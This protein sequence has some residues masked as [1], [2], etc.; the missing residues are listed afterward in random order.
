MF[1]KFI[2]K[3]VIKLLTT[4]NSVKESLKKELQ[5]VL[6]D[7]A[8]IKKFSEIARQESVE[9]VNSS[10]VQFEEKIE[11]NCKSKIDEAIE[12]NSPG[13]T[14]DDFDTL[15]E[16]I[17]SQVDILENTIANNVTQTKKLLDLI[18][19]L[20][21]TEKQ[22]KSLSDS[23]NIVSQIKSEYIET[24]KKTRADVAAIITKVKQDISDLEIRLD[25]FIDTISERIAEFK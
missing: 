4:D 21:N 6:I 16:Q 20:E 7:E 15:Q 13:I 14:I 24:N 17:D 22:I 23:K 9:I 1:E 11:E 12:I 10:L 19:R 25:A 5:H 2:S 3:I 18:S 8:N